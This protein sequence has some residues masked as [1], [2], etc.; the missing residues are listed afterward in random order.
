MK[1]IFVNLLLL[2]LE[3]IHVQKLNVNIKK[4]LIKTYVWSIA[5]SGC[6]TWVLN[7]T[8][9]KVLEAF[10]MWCW[11][12]MQRK[13]WMERKRNQYVLEIV[14]ENR[15][16]IDSIGERRW[17]MVGYTLRIQKNCTAQ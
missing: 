14:D 6:E 10:E 7:I 11:R 13:G 9:R 16:L 17:K 15:L 4:K 3:N 2:L 12:C 8:E 5:L 1:Y